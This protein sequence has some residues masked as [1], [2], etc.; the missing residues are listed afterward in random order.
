MKARYLLCCAA[1]ATA[2]TMPARAQDAPA[3][4]GVRAGPAGIIVTARKR[5]E[6]ILNV[7]V[8][9]AVVSAETLENHQIVD[10]HA[11][12]SFVPGIKMGNSVLTIGTQISLRGVGTTS[13]D[14]G[15]DQSVSLNI[16]GLQLSQGLAYQSGFFD[17]AQAEVL[18]GP[19]ALFFGKSSP[20]GVIALTTADPG[21]EWEAIGRASYEFQARQRRGELMLSGPLTDTFGVRLAG[22]L[23]KEDGWFK[24][25]AT[26]A[27]GLGGANPK[28]DRINPSKNWI[29]RG[30][31]VYE[32]SPAFRARLKVN[33]THDRAEG[34]GSPQVSSCPDGIGAPSGVPF[35]NPNEDCKY[36]RTHYLVDFSPA[37]FPLALNG[38]TPFLD[39]DQHFGTLEM[40]ARLTDGVTATS[41]SGY[42][43]A[44]SS[45][46]INSTSG[47]YAASLL[48]TDNRFRRRDLTQEFRIESD[49]GESPVNFLAGLFYQDGQV[50]NRITAGGNTALRLPALL[51]SG[52]HNLSIDSVSLFGQLR[53]KPVPVLEIAGGARWTSEQRSDRPTLI[54]AAAGG[55]LPV[56]PPTPKISSRNWSPELTATYTPTDDFTLFA[57]LKQA[58]KSG[59]F[60]ITNPQTRPVSDN[61]FGDERVR[62]A[63]VGIKARA[64]DRALFVNLAGYYYRYKGLQVGATEPTD[65]TGPSGGLPITRTLNA[66]S[67][68]VYGADFDAA[69][70][71]AGIEGLM[72]NA[73]LNWNHARF[74]KLENVPCYGGQ[75]IAAGCVITPIGTGVAPVQDLSGIPLVRAPEW[76][77]TFGFGYEMPVGSGMTLSLGNSNEYSSRYL[78]GLGRRR[79]LYQ[80]AYIKVNGYLALKA[81]NESWELSLVGNNL[82]NKLTSG[83]KLTSNFA[84]SVILFGQQTGTNGAGPAGVD[85]ILTFDEPGRQ[86][87]LKLTLRPFAFGK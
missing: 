37:A 74:L 15:I 71:P 35:F 64:F 33:F 75:T 65:P 54:N 32:P 19:Q 85:E 68:E 25:P 6:S 18:K 76:Q 70:R 23:S 21:K 13:L 53:W 40:V 48:Y 22:M 61:S 60:T 41:T 77:A 55:Y 45:T 69:F 34:G 20:G 72:L 79:D 7:P 30:T 12:T 29:M 24:N 80:R 10:L 26:A 83:N 50:Y 57:S 59:S 56:T 49:F 36:D 66:G 16:D 31:A 43:K 28:Y 8:V 5:Q 42:Y 81:A 4:D 63:E 46:F 11:L 3:A 67:A 17:L 9:E 47:G 84:N 73:A 52:E 44:K 86:V 38:G 82:N 78:A 1:A 58:Y 39:L 2:W 27:P 87:F 51:A 14:A 62:G